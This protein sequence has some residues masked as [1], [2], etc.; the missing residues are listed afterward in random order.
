MESNRNPRAWR[1]DLR[2]PALQADLREAA[3]EIRR[4]MEIAVTRRLGSGARAASLLSGGVD[5]PP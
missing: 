4:R 5:S 1:R 3:T 2:F